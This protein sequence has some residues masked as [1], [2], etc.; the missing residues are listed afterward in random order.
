V[1]V[2]GGW[3]PMTIICVFCGCASEGLQVSQDHLLREQHIG[4]R[5]IVGTILIALHC[6]GSKY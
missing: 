3:W 1:L 5:G 4:T 6:E 2:G